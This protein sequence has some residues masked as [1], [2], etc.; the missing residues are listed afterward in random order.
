MTVGDHESFRAV[1]IGLYYRAT[2]LPARPWLPVPLGALF[3]QA[4]IVH[5]PGLTL[6]YAPDAPQ[7]GNLIMSHSEAGAGTD[8]FGNPYQRGDTAYRDAFNR[9]SRR[10]RM[11]SYVPD[12]SSGSVPPEPGTHDKPTAEGSAEQEVG[13]RW[14]RG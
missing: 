2:E 8:D 13:R 12:A 9:S 6:V 4:T 11:G 3:D 5:K 14:A 1:L 7:Y 10:G